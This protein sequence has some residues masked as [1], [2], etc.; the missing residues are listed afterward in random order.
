MLIEVNTDNHIR[1]SA[2]LSA[3][4]EASVEAALSHFSD[5]VSRVEVHLADE[6]SQKGG[7][8]DV[9]CSMEARIDGHQ[10]LAATNHAD[11]VEDAVDGAAEKL[12]AAIESALGRLKDKR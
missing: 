5:R 7:G 3:K 10:P 2:E 11:S 4:V 12:T 9:R 8:S 6:N 1:G